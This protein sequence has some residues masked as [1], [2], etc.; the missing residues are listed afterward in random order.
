MQNDEVLTELE[1]S[2]SND[3][4]CV[5]KPIILKECGH[6]ACLNCLFNAA[7]ESKICKKCET[8]VSV[9]IKRGQE[10][11]N[12]ITNSLE[13]LMKMIEKQMEQQIH[14]I[15]SRKSHFS[16]NILLLF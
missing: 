10:P 11:E 15:K 12:L 7:N 14:K 6:F 3:D 8:K 2:L 5:I 9:E 1:C 16:P 4:H 13:N